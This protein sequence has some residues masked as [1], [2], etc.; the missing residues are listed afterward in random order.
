LSRK[1]V[2]G[3]M[4]EERI[5][6]DNYMF[7][8]HFY[9]YELASKYIS[10]TSI[11][12]EAGSGDGYGSNYMASLCKRVVGIDIEREPLQEARGKYDSPQLDFVQASVLELPIKAKAADF[13]C[14]MQVIE[15][16]ND[17]KPYLGAL[18][19]V[20]TDTGT[21]FITTPY[22]ESKGWRF[23][24]IPS[25]FHVIEYTGPELKELLSEFFSQVEIN[26]IKFKETSE[27]AKSDS[28]LGR[29]QSIDK[30]N[31]RRL[32]PSFAKPILYRLTGFKPIGDIQMSISDFEMIH[33]VTDE[34]LDLVA[35]CHK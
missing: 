3:E 31:L 14:S 21:V 13:V 23:D 28:G 12:I 6:P 10:P 35:V 20:V 1:N 2:L 5:R 33:G 7:A 18:R 4:V 16:L 30:F 27:A 34:V 17:P 9:A 32:V 26:G 19:E 29:V 15:H 8:R 24:K 25:P 22:R 11:A